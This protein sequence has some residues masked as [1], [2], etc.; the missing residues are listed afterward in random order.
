V[1]VY[2][3]CKKLN[4]TMRALPV[5]LIVDKEGKLTHLPAG[6]LSFDQKG[7]DAEVTRNEEA[8][9]NWTA[10]IVNDK[11]ENEPET[12]PRKTDASSLPSLRPKWRLKRLKAS[13][14]STR[15]RRDTRFTPCR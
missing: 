7:L 8:P 6:K 12:G 3:L 14:R 15:S 13:S 9:E 10:G 4:V 5:M 2:E 11:P 1:R